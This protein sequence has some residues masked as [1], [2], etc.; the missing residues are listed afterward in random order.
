MFRRFFL[1]LAVTCS[2]SFV[3]TGC[4]S[5]TGNKQTKE[6]TESVFANEKQDMSERRETAGVGIVVSGADT[7]GA[8][9][10]DKVEIEDI[11]RTRLTYQGNESTV[12]YITSVD[13]LPDYEELAQYDANF[14]EENALVVVT[15]S[16]NSGSVD[17]GIL[18]ISVEDE[19]ASVSLYHETTGDNVTSDMATWLLWAVVDTGLD[20]YQWEVANPALAS[21]LVTE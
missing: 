17:T 5:K 18:S 2:F 12:K 3:F 11:G 16:V 6:S 14:F 1:I 15:E 7:A 8:Q 4:H 21:S 20:A 13:E 9:K 19:V 10:G